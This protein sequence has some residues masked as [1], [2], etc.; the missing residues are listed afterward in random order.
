MRRVA[1]VNLLHAASRARARLGYMAQ[2]FSLYG[3]LS[4][5]TEPRLLR[6]HLRAVARRAS[7]SVCRAHDRDVRARADTCTSNAALLP[8]GFKQRLAL[9]CAVL[10][11]AAGAVSRRADLAASIR[12]MRRE[13]WYAHQRPGRA[14]RDRDGDDAL[15]GRGR[16]LRPHRAHLS[17]PQDRD[18]L[19]RMS[20]RRAPAA[21]QRPSRRWRTPSSRSSKAEGT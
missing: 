21:P 17:R 15:H 8:L 1:G 2:K 11:A 13:F 4:V 6:R 18:G 14:R 12:S 7:A 9:A 5:A 20:S 10:H 3:D 19:A 16:V